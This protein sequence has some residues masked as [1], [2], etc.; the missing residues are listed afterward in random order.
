MGRII[1]VLLSRIDEQMLAALKRGLEQAFNRLVEARVKTGN[2]DY[3]YDSSRMQYLCPRLLSRL[4]RIKKDRGDK[5][6]G[7]V[8]VD[9]YSPGFDFVFGEADVNAGVASVSLYRLP[10]EYSW[11][12]PDST[13]FEERAIKAAIHELGHLYGL[14]HCQNPKCV[15]HFSTSL[16]D[17]DRTAKLFCASCRERLR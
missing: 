4:C 3:A 11:Q 12:P 14:R 1:L 10:P 16:A 8:D 5:V 2:L 13:V 15:M 9:L 7:L 6:I 17:I